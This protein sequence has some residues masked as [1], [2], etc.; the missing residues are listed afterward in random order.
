M[1]KERDQSL[2]QSCGKTTTWSPS[3]SMQME[4]E[5]QVHPL[6]ENI[7]PQDNRPGSFTRFHEGGDPF[8]N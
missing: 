7:I 3:H 6:I 4:L 2:V 8:Q 5:P 1:K